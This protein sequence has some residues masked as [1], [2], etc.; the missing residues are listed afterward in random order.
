MI[1]FI[2]YVLGTIPKKMDIA[3]IYAIVFGVL[4]VTP[5]AF[6]ALV[7]LH[8]TSSPTTVDTKDHTDRHLKLC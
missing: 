7:L 3:H 1:R 2:H 4:V 5:G 6:L 8:V